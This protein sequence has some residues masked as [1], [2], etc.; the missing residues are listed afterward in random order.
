MG[1]PMSWL[2]AA[3]SHH[4]LMVLPCMVV[5]VISARYANY[6]PTRIRWRAPPIR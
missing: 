6:R 4:L 3:T 5:I 1:Q 2:S